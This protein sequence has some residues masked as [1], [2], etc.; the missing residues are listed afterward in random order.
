MN[1]GRGFAAAAALVCLAFAGAGEAR[2]IGGFAG[3]PMDS[4]PTSCF[5]E[6]FGGVQGACSGT[7][8]W[9][10]PLVVDTAGGKTIN[11]TASAGSSPMTCTAYGAGPS[12]QFDF[13]QGGS[14][15]WQNT[16]PAQQSISVPTV[17][18]GGYLYVNC[19]FTGLGVTIDAVNWNS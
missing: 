1:K 9:Q 2:T 19:S 3:H 13:H 6:W 11:I 15:T 18:S 12:G 4:S 7:H 10:I 8:T 14:A 16:N 17:P 5:T